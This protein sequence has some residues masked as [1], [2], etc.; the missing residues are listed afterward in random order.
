MWLSGLWWGCSPSRPTH[1]AHRCLSRP[2]RTRRLHTPV[3]VHN[4]N[5]LN[6]M[7]TA[8]ILAFPAPI[9]QVVVI[10]A[11]ASVCGFPFSVVRMYLFMNNVINDA[12]YHRTMKNTDFGESQG[13]DFTCV[14]TAMPATART[15]AV[16]P[17]SWPLCSFLYIS[18]TR[19]SERAS[20]TQPATLS[21]NF[22]I[23]KPSN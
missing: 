7:K 18:P 4:V 16:A 2:N 21:F 8:R 9:T 10:W 14:S 22:Q 19:W 20:G 3:C 6:V 11:T 5:K 12:M 1:T 23:A 17:F 15:T 13:V